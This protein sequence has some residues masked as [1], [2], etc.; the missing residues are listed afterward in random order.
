MKLTPF[1]D[2]PYKLL[3]KSL[4][5]WAYVLGKK[6]FGRTKTFSSL[7]HALKIVNLYKENIPI[8]GQ[9]ILEIG[10]GNDISTAILM[11]MLGA[12][13][14]YLVD[15]ISDFTDKGHSNDI[16][17]IKAFQGE[18]KKQ[19]WSLNDES[20]QLVKDKIKFIDSYFTDSEQLFTGIKE[21]DC[22]VSHQVLEHIDNLDEAFKNMK[23][24]LKPGG[25][26]FHE[27]DF[28]DHTMHIFGRYSFLNFLCRHNLA[29]LFY[30]DRF[31]KIC[32]D[33]VRLNMNRNILPD[34]L[35]FLERYG[36]S[37]LGLFRQKA[38]RQ[39]EI[40]QDI[41]GRVDDKLKTDDYLQLLSVSLQAK[42]NK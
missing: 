18:L 22:I 31:W 37:V 14:V 40:H 28:S 27:I 39:Q 21:V 29:H 41:L 9:T 30:S 5:N 13:Q 26:M 11:V 10:P 36:F 15:K 24:M 7:E 38:E 1:F 17:F 2:V 32:N 4:P 25:I 12:K 35:V 3:R 19:K 16:E 6:L 34:Y 20:P 23:R 33:S 8:E 42:L